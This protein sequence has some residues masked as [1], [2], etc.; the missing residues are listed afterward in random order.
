M[1]RP[2]HSK[3]RLFL[4]FLAVCSGAAAAAY[5]TPLESWKSAGYLLKS[6]EEIA[7]YNEYSDRQVGIRKWTTP[8]RYFFV[9]RVGDQEL[10]ER[11]TK[12]HIKH[13]SNITGLS[14]SPAAT[15]KEA[16]L[17][18]I[19]STEMKLQNELLTDFGIRSSQQRNDLFRHSV[20]LGSFSVAADA[21]ITR[22]VVIIPVDRAAAHAKL[23]DCIVE[24][25]TQILGLPNDSEKVFPSIFN[26]K[27]VNSL[28][29]GLDYLLLKML[30]DPRIKTGMTFVQAAPV[31]K[32]IVDEYERD[33]LIETAE[34]R[35]RTGELYDL[36]Y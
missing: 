34:A 33:K 8:I 36:L 11:L 23:I 6:F 26:D 9:H 21:S 7:M 13:L 30:Y 5:A 35:V 20:C 25:I 32:K 12:M 16:N 4:V 2:I 15:R 18:I 27:S 19:F 29:S 22:A 1:P 10:H 24:E 28:L 14:I 31:L 3:I 17:L